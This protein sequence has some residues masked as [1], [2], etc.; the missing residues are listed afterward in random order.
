RLAPEHPF[1]TGVNDAYAAVKRVTENAQLLRVSLDKG[2]IVGGDSSG[3]N[4][5]TVCAHL[6][7]RDD[8]FL[9][10]KVTG[11]L[12]RQPFVI[13]PD[14]CPKQYKSDYRSLE[15]FKDAPLLT[16]DTLDQSRALLQAAPDDPQFSPLLFP[17][18]VGVAPAFV[19]YNGT[20]I[21]RDDGRI[22]ARVLSD[23]GVKVKAEWYVIFCSY[24]TIS[25]AKKL[26]RHTR[27]GLTW[28]LAGAP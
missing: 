11:Q 23:A 18:H 15:E 7:R 3:A 27:G 14:A 24:P 1:P 6:A 25:M 28:L 16:R 17:S 13:D 4:L 2:F 19:T 26:D 20:D 22:Y 9:G 8:P 5:A 12:L 21:L 10:Y